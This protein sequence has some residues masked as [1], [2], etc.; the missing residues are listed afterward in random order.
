[1]KNTIHS[2]RLCFTVEEMHALLTKALADGL[3]KKMRVFSKTATGT[4]LRPVM[5]VD[6]G[7]SGVILSCA[8]PHSTSWGAAVDW[9]QSNPAIAAKLGISR[10][11]VYAMRKRCA[12]K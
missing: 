2:P 7:E 9:S 10:Q 3:D 12:Q 8:P 6:V 1:M 4:G 5:G 11:A